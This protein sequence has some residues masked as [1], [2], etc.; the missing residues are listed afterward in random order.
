MKERR[1]YKR[2]KILKTIMIT[3]TTLLLS[4]SAFTAGG[5]IRR[6]QWTSEKR[7]A[8]ENFF[9]GK[10]KEIE[11]GTEISIIELKKQML[12]VDL[13]MENVKIDINGEEQPSDKVYKFLKVDDNKIKCTLTEAVEG[14]KISVAKTYIY[15][16]I[17]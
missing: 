13:S 6:A 17:C 15:K 7:K 8:F 1:S 11:Y 5:I 2:E 10:D 12:K 14:E 4:V 16:V 9:I 3:I